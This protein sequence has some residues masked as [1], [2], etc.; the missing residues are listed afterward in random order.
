[1]LTEKTD[2]TSLNQ[3]AYAAAIIAIKTARVENE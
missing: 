3:L 2:V 1:M